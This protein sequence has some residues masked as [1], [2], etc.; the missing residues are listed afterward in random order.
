MYGDAKPIRRLA[1]RV[2]L[3]SDRDRILLFRWVF[4][5]DDPLGL[6][7]TPGGG[8]HNG[9]TFEQAAQR[10]LWEETGLAGEDLGPCIWNRRHFAETRGTLYE[11]VDGRSVGT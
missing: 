10:E 3:I 7:I 5:E 8:L 2:L 9:E 6:W 4:D 1:A 11:S